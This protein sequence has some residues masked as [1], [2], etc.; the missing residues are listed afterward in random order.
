MAH[1]DP[2]TKT[3]NRAALKDS[4]QREIDLAKRNSRHLSIIFFDL[5]HFK[6]I[7][8]EY[9]HECGDIALTAAA[10]CIKD[11]T[12][13]SDLLFRYGGEEF[14]LLLSDTQ[15]YAARFLAERI[16][17]RIEN[18]TISCGMKTLKLTAS[19]G[20]SSL[21]DNDTPESLISRADKAMYQAKDR[22]R[23]QVKTELSLI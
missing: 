15:I 2:L 10:T 17:R 23:N 5:D 8:D 12:R 19:L 18:H 16:R 4:L 7:N 22:G 9:G 11:S 6:A 21:K 20:I 13:C 1:T 3:L 14:V